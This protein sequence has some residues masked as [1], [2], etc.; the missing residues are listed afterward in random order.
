M[1]TFMEL[2]GDMRNVFFDEIQNV[3]GWELFIN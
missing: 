2:F 3:K 1:E